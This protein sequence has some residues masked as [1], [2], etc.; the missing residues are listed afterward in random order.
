MNKKLGRS[1]KLAKGLLIYFLLTVGVIDLRV[2]KA[3]SQPIW[4]INADNKEEPHTMDWDDNS[5]QEYPQDLEVNW[6]IILNI[7]IKIIPHRSELGNS[8]S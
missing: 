2:Q 8:Q 7:M 1:K 3:E 4:E 6:E 5:K